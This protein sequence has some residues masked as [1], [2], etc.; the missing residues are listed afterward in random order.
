MVCEKCQKQ[1]AT[2]HLT[3]I[4]N[5]EKRE[6]H[7]CEN[8]ARTA[9]VGLKVNFSISDIL[10]NLIEQRGTKEIPDK[11]CPDCGIRYSDF[12]SKARL[13][14][15]RDYDFF[16]GAVG[17][18]LEKI[19]GSVQHV[20]KVPRT[21]DGAIVKENLLVRLKR[22]LDGLIKAERFEDAAQVRDRIRTL[23]VEL[24]RT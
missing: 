1:H 18:L 5:D 21:A 2:V 20:G 8:C 3:E 23:E 4:V 9:G 15:A 11:Q 10:G 13:G 16:Q 14:C 7:L 19:H 12:R 24:G 22:D 17:S 6:A